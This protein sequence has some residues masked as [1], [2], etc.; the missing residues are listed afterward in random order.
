MWLQRP[1]PTIRT[2]TTTTAETKRTIRPNASW[3]VKR[4]R[5]RCGGRGRSWS[6]GLYCNFLAEWTD[7]W[8]W[9]PAAVKLC[10]RFGVFWYTRCTATSRYDPCRT[11]CWSLIAERW[12]GF[13]TGL[14][15]L[16]I[17]WE[18][19]CRCR[20][21]D[22][23]HRVRQTVRRQSCQNRR[24]IF[25]SEKNMHD[26]HGAER[27]ITFIVSILYF[28]GITNFILQRYRNIS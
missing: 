13:L 3:S 19:R 28:T 11:A 18:F 7:G 26:A 12:A 24:R 15:R 25:C 6:I 20:R 16:W 14:E 22:G 5:R 2:A 17:K 10:A 23:S 8:L 21:S 1:E 27:V 9:G 4:F